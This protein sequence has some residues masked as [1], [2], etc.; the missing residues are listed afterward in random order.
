M[1]PASKSNTKSKDKTSAKSA[2][3]QPKASIKSS[4]STNSVT[5][6]PANAYNPISGTFHTLEIPAAAAFLPLHDNGRFRNIDDTDEH[7]SSP[8]GTVSEYD[9]VSNNGSC[10]GESEDI[11]EKIIN[12][13]RQETI[14]GLD[15]DRRE[16]IRQR[17]EKKHQRQRERRAQELHDRCSGYLMS[18]KLERLSQQ[19]VA[20]GFSHERAILALMLNEGRVEESVNWLFEGSEEEAQKDSKLESGGNLKID[21]NEELAQ[22]SAMEMRYKCSKQEV[23]RAVV[24]CEG[25]L[26]K[27][28]ETLQPQKQEP[29]AT[30]PRQEYTADTNNLRRLH[31]K[32]VPVTSVTA[33][34]R[35]NERDFNY[36]TAIP[37]P[38]YSEPGSRNL[39]SLNQP[40]PLAD[41]RWGATGSSPAFSSSMGPSM[42]VAPPSTKL[43]VQ[44]GFTEGV[45]TTGSSSAFS[46][47]MGPSMQVAPPSSMGPSMQVAP[48][49]TKLGVQLGFTGNER[50]NVQQIVREPVSPQSMNAK[51]NTVPYA[52][53]TPS[54]TAGWYSNNVPGVEHMRSNVKL[55]SNQST[56]SLGLV[57]Q[58][59]QQFYHPVSY[60]QNPFPYSGPVN[61]TSNGLGGTRSPSLTVPSQ[62]QGSY[63][64]TTAS[65]PSLAAPSSLGLFI[66]WGSAGTLGSSHVDWNTGGLMSE[67]D[68]TS[69]DW[70]LDSNMLS[71]KSNG[72]WLGLSSLL[73]NTSSTRTS[74]TNSSFL[75]GLRDSGVAKET[76]SSAG[77]REWTSPFAGKD[78]FSLPRQFVTSPSP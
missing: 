16:K 48:P 14:P 73:R 52:S 5:G 36:K 3:E 2:I 74:S 66:G 61:Y 18:R 40:K 37:V 71:S 21:I 13:T 11:K 56:G 60:K 46:S 41:K 17:N 26:V 70:T 32:P 42:Q 64:K 59:S 65:L 68:Y 69:I 7:S 63:G 47:S 31:E 20:M 22:I 38:T 12:S 25:D 27:A 76:S 54:V 78:I 30:P 50:K 58:S 62:L 57:N 67:F 24:A 77:S 72:L 44:L 1:S 45:G 29:P 49:S 34:Q 53:A 35:M 23:E 6:N 43:D 19:L 9:S 39:Q 10:S 51:Q 55:L 15:S 8:H 33:Q 75:S 28:E 4:G